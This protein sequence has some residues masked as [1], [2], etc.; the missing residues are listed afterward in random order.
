MPDLWPDL[1][2]PICAGRITPAVEYWDGEPW[3]AG[4]ECERPDCDAEWDVDGKARVRTDSR[5]H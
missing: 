3:P 2:C 4:F 5:P 1:K